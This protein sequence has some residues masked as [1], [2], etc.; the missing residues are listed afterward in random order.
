MD[1]SHPDNSEI[2]NAF[3]DMFDGLTVHAEVIAQYLGR[4]LEP[5]YFEISDNPLLVPDRD[6]AMQ[7]ATDLSELLQHKFGVDYSI[8]RFTL[9]KHDQSLAVIGYEDSEPRLCIARGFFEAEY[10]DSGEPGFAS[11]ATVYSLFPPI[12]VQ[13]SLSGIIYVTDVGSD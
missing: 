5:I 9:V 2:D 11:L 7:R 10:V 1:P 4:E 8:D 3:D 6:T 12:A 13:E